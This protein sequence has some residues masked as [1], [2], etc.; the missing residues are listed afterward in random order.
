MTASRQQAELIEGWNQ[1][2]A[3][4]A[5]GQKRSFTS[6]WV[7]LFEKV[8]GEWNMTKNVSNFKPGRK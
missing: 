8:S 6:A 3:I 1:Q 2:V 7:S 5:S 4:A